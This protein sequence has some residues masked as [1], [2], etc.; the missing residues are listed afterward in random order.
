MADC[1]VCGEKVAE[2]VAKEARRKGRL[3][4]FCGRS[5]FL[6]S[7][8]KPRAFGPA[9]PRALKQHGHNT[10]KD[11]QSPTYKAWHSMKQRC[12]NP[13][14]SAFDHY[15]GRGI[16]V[17]ERWLEFNLFLRD[18]GE[19]PVG[20]SIDRINPDG[21]YEPANCRW[22]TAKEQCNN[23]RRQHQFVVNYGGVDYSLQE[24]AE[25]FGIDRYTLRRRVTTSRWPERYWHLKPDKTFTPR[26]RMTAEE[27]RRKVFPR[28][29]E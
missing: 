26:E 25:K 11:G 15:G 24:L 4:R 13:S 10:S 5:C 23:W 3:V 19:R 14:H 8:R 9:R 20:M 29:R 18:M 27:Q 2:A 12:L 21:N 6:K 16:T 17:C 7:V 1:E 22:A 28:G